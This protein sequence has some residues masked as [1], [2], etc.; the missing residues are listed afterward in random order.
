MMAASLC[1]GS[2]LDGVLSL[3]SDG[4]NGV[5][6]VEVHELGKIELGLLE[7]L[8]LTDHAVVLER[9]DL[10]ALLL[11]LLANIVLDPIVV[12]KINN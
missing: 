10:A 5:V 2:L 1:S 11:D 4:G 8:A 3:R 6:L 12:T 7:E 9:E